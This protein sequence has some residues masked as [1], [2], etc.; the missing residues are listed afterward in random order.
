MNRRSTGFAFT[1][2][3]AAM[4]AACGGGEEQG[5]PDVAPQAARVGIRNLHAAPGAQRNA[6]T[7]AAAPEA[8]A[9]AEAGTFATIPLATSKPFPHHTTYTSGVIK[10]TNVSQ[11]TMDSKVQSYYGSWKS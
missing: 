10:P 2:V 7:E 6:S 4:L 3:T 1:V 9:Q 8:A 11:S 5:S